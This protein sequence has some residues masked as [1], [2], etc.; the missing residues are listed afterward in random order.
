ML[1]VDWLTAENAETAEMDLNGV[2]EQIIGAAIDVHR[3]LGPGLLES[4]YESCMAYELAERGLLVERQKVLPIVYKGVNIAYA[5]RIDLL[6]ERQVVVELK[7]VT[8]IEPVHQA[9]MLSYLKLSG[10]PVGLLINFNVKQ[11]K[12]G[13][14]RVVHSHSDH[15]SAVSA[16]S[17][18]SARQAS[19]GK[20]DDVR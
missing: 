2:T 1:G 9:Q 5:Y 7:S 20:S 13:V 11:L 14:R 8:H 6:V 15:T 18:V 4:T 19:A 3:V 12:T 17:A 16:F 10:C